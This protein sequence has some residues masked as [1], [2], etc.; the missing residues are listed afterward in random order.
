MR[1]A[2]LRGA[3]DSLFFT[4]DGQI[5]D[6]GCSKFFL[7]LDGRWWT[8]PLTEGALPGVMQSLL[9]EDPAWQA[10]ERTLR[11]PDVHRARSLI[12]CNAVHG[13]VPGRLV[14]DP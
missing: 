11:L 6:D 4:A 10:G 2:R 3:Y 13:A 1:R 7:L 9:L 8:P 12:V 5:V 14:I